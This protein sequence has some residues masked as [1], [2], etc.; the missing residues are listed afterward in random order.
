MKVHIEFTGFEQRLFVDN[1]P[2]YAKIYEGECSPPE[3]FN[4]LRI[5]LDLSER[6]LLNWNQAS[7]LA[8]R[9]VDKGLAILWELQFD[10]LEGSLEDETRFLTFQ[11]NIQHFI[12]TLW[13]DFQSHTFG[14]AL[15]R[16]ILQEGILDY[17][18]TLAALLDEETTCFLFL[19]A[20]SA[21][22]MKSY[23]HAVDMTSLS[24]FCPIVKGKMAE[25]YPWVFPAL[26]WGSGASSLG[27]CSTESHPQLPAVHLGYALC[28]PETPLWDQFLVAVD[29]MK[30]CP[31]RILP[32]RLLTHEWEG[33]DKLMIFPQACTEKARRMFLG[34]KAAGGEIIEFPN[35]AT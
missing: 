31:F 9:A 29:R 5:P 14:I 22:D 4:V 16:G 10:L 13:K 7:H 34:F 23:L 35:D 32:E 24:F 12:D 26:A 6:S 20:S 18:K 2:F 15:F 3:D 19:D 1:Q 28:L 17:L 8:T 11:L 25:K 30:E 27:F 33:I 21:T